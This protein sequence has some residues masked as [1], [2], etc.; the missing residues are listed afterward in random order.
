SSLSP[1]AARRFEPVRR[2]GRITDP[3]DPASTQP[4]NG[5]I[6]QIASPCTAWA[7]GI[8]SK[9]PGCE[10]RVKRVR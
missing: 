1:R 3:D 9:G 4:L 7:W 6:E 2:S 10:E 5:S 8:G